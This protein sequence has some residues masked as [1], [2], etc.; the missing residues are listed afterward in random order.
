LII[1]ISDQKSFEAFEEGQWNKEIG[2]DPQ[3]E[4]RGFKK[5]WIR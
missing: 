4:S 5:D 3:K 1:E 2:F